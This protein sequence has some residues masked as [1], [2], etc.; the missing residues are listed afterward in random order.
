MA[1]E[2]GLE[3]LMK[4]DRNLYFINPGMPLGDDHEATVDGVHP[5]DMGHERILELIRPKVEKILRKY[6]VK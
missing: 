2:E 1:A 4:E 5:T 6:G 3:Q